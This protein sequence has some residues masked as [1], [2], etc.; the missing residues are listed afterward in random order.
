METDSSTAVAWTKDK[1]C[2]PWQVLREWKEIQHILASLQQWRISHVFREGNQVADYLAAMRTT[3][4]NSILR[5][6]EFDPSLHLILS[7]DAAGQRYT[8]SCKS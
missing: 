3:S 1:G 8:R 4:R 6:D 2:L 7:K 5:P